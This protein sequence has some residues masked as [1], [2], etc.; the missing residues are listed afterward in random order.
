SVVGRI[1]WQ[2]AVD[3][4]FPQLSLAEV[5]RALAMLESREFIVQRGAPMFAG[6]TEYSFRNVLTRDVAY[7][8]LPKSLRGDAHAHVGAWIAGK[9]GDRVREF[10]DLLAFHYEQALLLG[11][12]MQTLGPAAVPELEDK[13]IHYL[14][15]AGDV[16]H[17]RLALAEAEQYYWRALEIMGTSERFPAEGERGPLQDR[18]PNILC[19][20]AD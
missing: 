15:L 3:E 7:H 6:E 16:A 14:E 12:E 1:F 9:A 19:S 20:Y 17:E 2:G 8:S 11:R 18:Y 13:A 10:A 5:R 4:M